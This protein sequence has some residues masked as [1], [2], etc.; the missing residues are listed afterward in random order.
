MTSALTEALVNGGAVC[1][2]RVFAILH[3]L[4][5]CRSTVNTALILALQPKLS[6]MPSLASLTDPKAYHVLT[7][8]TLL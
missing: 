4:D 3:T 6:T 1:R 8:G 2:V 5:C 7:Y